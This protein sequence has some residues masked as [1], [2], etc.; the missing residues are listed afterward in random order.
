M[1]NERHT[2][3]TENRQ[4]Y[5]QTER[6]N[7]CKALR[8]L[9]ARMRAKQVLVRSARFATVRTRCTQAQRSQLRN[10]LCARSL[11]AADHA[12]AC[13]RHVY[14]PLSVR[15]RALACVAIA[16]N[17][18]APHTD[19]EN[20]R[21]QRERASE[22]SRK[23]G[24]RGREGDASASNNNV[25]IRFQCLRQLLSKQTDGIQTK[26]RT[27]SSVFGLFSNRK[28]RAYLIKL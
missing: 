21:R 6:S 12:M 22:P 17:K 27:V 18:S 28:P 3:S 23:N 7:V 14:Q 19:R 20:G 26:K 11:A 1:S 2:R 16:P 25:V 8:A 5:A 24:R 13:Q 4:E 9:A 10:Q 15:L